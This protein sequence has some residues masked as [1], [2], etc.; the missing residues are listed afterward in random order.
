MSFDTP[1]TS[2][3]MITDIGCDVSDV[4]NIMLIHAKATVSNRETTGNNNYTAV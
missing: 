4:S 1:V 2:H 3:T